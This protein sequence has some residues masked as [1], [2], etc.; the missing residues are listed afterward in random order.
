MKIGRIWG[1]NLYLNPFFLALLGLFFVAGILDRGLIAFGVVLVHE[2]AHAVVAKRLGVAVADVELLPFGGVTRMA[3]DMAV[4]PR[5]EIHIAIAGPTGNLVLFLAGMALKN[6]GLWDDELNRFFLQCNVLIA[7]FN[8]L[9]ALPL[10]GGR[11]YRAFLAGRIGVRNATC[12]AAGLGQAWGVAVILAG[13]AGLALG[14]AGLDILITGLFLLYAAT[15]ERTA[16]PYLF[17]RHMIQKKEDLIRE[18]VLPAVTLVAREDAVLGEVV[19]LFMPRRFHFV[20]VFSM[21]LEF[22]GVLSEDKI[23]DGLFNFGFDHPVG[24]IDG[25]IS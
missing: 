23:I 21:G 14:R 10:D 20:A 5:Q 2:L 4:N 15:R 19:R 24:G 18:G 7:L 3:G 9:P 25:L 17:I 11:V 1:I 22:K 8:I 12:R 16:A 6:Y 13:A